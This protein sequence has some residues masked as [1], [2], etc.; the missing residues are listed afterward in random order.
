MMMG[1]STTT[2]TTTTTTAR[3]N[4][5]G[6]CTADSICLTGQCIGGYFGR[7]ARCCGDTCT[8]ACSDAGRCYPKLSF[9]EETRNLWNS[10]AASA[11]GWPS[12]VNAGQLITGLPA[13]P[14]FLLGGFERF[15]PSAESTAVP[16]SVD[17]AHLKYHLRWGL[18]SNDGKDYV[19]ATPPPG[20]QK[21]GQGADPGFFSVDSN[22]GTVLALPKRTG[23]YSLFLIVIDETPSARTVYGMSSNPLGAWDQVVVATWS[24]EVRGKPTFSVTSFARASAAPYTSPKYVTDQSPDLECYVGGTYRVAPI[25]LTTFGTV[26][27]SVIY[28]SNNADDNTAKFTFTLRGA[29]PGFFIEANSGEILAVPTLPTDG[30]VDA[31]LWVV[32]RLGEEAFVQ[33]IRVVVNTPPVLNITLRAERIESGSEYTDPNQNLDGY[34]VNQNYLIAPY[35]I[36]AS[37]TLVSSGTINDIKYTLANAPA[38]WFISSE[39]GIIT[40][41]SCLK[42]GNTLPSCRESAQGHCVM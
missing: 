16:F 9:S 38:G 37:A 36:D 22:A 30:S 41:Q 29:P 8:T 13:P 11:L 18:P 33:N 34:Y 6:F 21:G 17:K 42:A 27:E 28:G 23:N 1:K 2:S 19:G 31:A 10:S 26:H 15:L 3:V 25:N 39:T 7:Y 4:P 14:G 35:Q 24:F 40:G 20:L 12:K 32:D 5:G